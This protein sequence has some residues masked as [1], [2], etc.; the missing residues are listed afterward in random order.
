MGIFKISSVKKKVTASNQRKLSEMIVYMRSGMEIDL[1]RRVSHE[2]KQQC[3][4][5]ILGI[6]RGAAGLI[7]HWKSLSLLTQKA[8]LQHVVSRLIK[9]G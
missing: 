6:I 1:S 4:G 5:L 3:A 8:L 7:P 2:L 9:C